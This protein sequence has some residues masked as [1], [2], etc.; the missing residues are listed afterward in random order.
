MLNKY[1]KST[2]NFFNRLICCKISGFTKNQ[3]ITLLNSLPKLKPLIPISSSTTFDD[4]LLLLTRVNRS[5]NTRIWLC[6]TDTLSNNS[7][8]RGLFSLRSTLDNTREIF[9][10]SNVLIKECNHLIR[11]LS[12]SELTKRLLFFVLWNIDTTYYGKRS[13]KTFINWLYS[14]E[15]GASFQYQTETT[16]LLHIYF[17]KIWYEVNDKQS[18]RSLDGMRACHSHIRALNELILLFKLFK[19]E[20]LFVDAKTLKPLCDLSADS[21]ILMFFLWYLQRGCWSIFSDLTITNEHVFRLYYAKEMS[22]TVDETHKIALSTI[23]YIC[24]V[25]LQLQL[26]Y[27]LML[28]DPTTYLSCLSK[29]K[30]L[31]KYDKDLSYGYTQAWDHSIFK[32]SLRESDEN[33]NSFITNMRKADRLYNFRNDYNVKSPL[34]WVHLWEQRLNFLRNLD[35]TLEIQ[36]EQTTHL[37]YHKLNIKQKKIS[38]LELLRTIIKYL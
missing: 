27:K 28:I 18:W 8:A 26:F 35:D 25:N 1:Y 36:F 10:S 29:E 21:K 17:F 15:V 37:D 30:H 11:N 34:S 38:F 23:S 4:V 6:Y 24:C 32:K 31:F 14:Y 19:S 33:L 2:K 5:I 3:C 9:D 20:K 12:H 16:N 7:N 13:I 22:V